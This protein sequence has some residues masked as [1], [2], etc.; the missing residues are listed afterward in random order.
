MTKMDMDM[1]MDMDKDNKKIKTLAE[2]WTPE[3]E[4]LLDS[5]LHDFFMELVKENVHQVHK[6]PDGYYVGVEEGLGLGALHGNR[7]EKAAALFTA[8][9]GIKQERIDI[10]LEYV[11]EYL[12]NILDFESSEPMWEGDN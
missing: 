8:T 1:D 5:V 12:D 4:D 6:C 2:W 3:R 9:H 7:D 10:V 11:R